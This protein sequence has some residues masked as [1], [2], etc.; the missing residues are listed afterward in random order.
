ME[1]PEVWTELQKRWKP[2]DH[3]QP[4]PEAERYYKTKFE[5]VKAINPETICE[6][7][8][9]CGYSM[10][11]F[12]CAAPKAKFIG[13]DSKIDEE[14]P[15]HQGEAEHAQ[16]ICRGETAFIYVDSQKL[17]K[18]PMLGGLLH[19]DADH[20]YEG[21][22]HD[23]ELGRKYATWILV[24]D[25][26][27]NVNVMKACKDFLLNNPLW[28]GEYIPDGFRGNLLLKELL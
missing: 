21:C 6:I 20:S 15:G 7:G 18:L 27:T 10:F 1:W 3:F 25:F 28:I 23:I 11:V 24:D 9:R 26:D 17:E 5:T 4:S 14:T 19:V 12:Q 13:I 2:N 16:N 8:V 22:S